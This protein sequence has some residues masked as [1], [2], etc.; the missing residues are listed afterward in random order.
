M[1]DNVLRVKEVSCQENPTG[2]RA[3][4][5]STNLNQGGFCCSFI[6]EY[7][8]LMAQPAPTVVKPSPR[9]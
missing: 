1:P 7:L 8:N 6:G 5:L 9:I 3:L 2:L 4:A